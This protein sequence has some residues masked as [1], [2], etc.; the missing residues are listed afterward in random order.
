METKEQAIETAV[1]SSESD[2]DEQSLN[3]M[4]TS[5]FNAY[6]SREQVQLPPGPPLRRLHLYAPIV[7]HHVPL[8]Q[9]FNSD[10]VPVGQPV[11]DADQTMMSDEHS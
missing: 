5:E 3:R 11:E 2:S 8:K 9:Q 10:A 4:N 7:T 1:D 6:Y